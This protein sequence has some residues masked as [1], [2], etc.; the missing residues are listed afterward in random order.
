MNLSG[1]S[2]AALVRELEIPV[3]SH[4][5]IVIYDELAFRWARFASRARFG[6]RAQRSEVDLRRRWARRSG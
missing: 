4:D 6:E 3:P 5:V 2:V 1:L